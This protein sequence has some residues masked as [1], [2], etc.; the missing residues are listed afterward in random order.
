MRCY[1]S[2]LYADF[3]ERY[4]M[5]ECQLALLICAQYD[6]Q[7]IINDLWTSVIERELRAA[8]L[9]VDNRIHK[10]VDGCGCVRRSILQ[11]IAGG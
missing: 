8:R 9:D 11:A 10:C 2:T 1:C 3:A 6:D 7:Q 5:F 4:R